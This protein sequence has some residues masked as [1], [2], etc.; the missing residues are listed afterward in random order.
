MLSKKY[1]IFMQSA[2]YVIACYWENTEFLST[3]LQIV[4]SPK[5]LQARG[6]T[7]PP[8]L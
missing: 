5:T 4:F 2:I 6:E 3:D 7:H 1:T 8:V